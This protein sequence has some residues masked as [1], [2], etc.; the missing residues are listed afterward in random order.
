MLL[1]DKYADKIHGIITCY[2]RMIIQG[3]IPN[4]SHAEAMT[5]YMKLNGIRIF[6]YPTSFSQ[7]LT[8]QVRQNA[9][10]IAHEN[11]MEIEFIR[12]LHAFRKDDR[13][14]NIIA[15]TG[16]TEGLIHIFSAMECCNT[17]RPWHDKTTGK[18]FLKF[19]QSKCLHYYFYFIDRELGLCYLRVPTW[20]P[21]RLQFYMNGHNLLAYKLDKK[22]LSYRMQDN[23]F[24]EIS[25]IETAQKLSDRINPQGLH[26]VLDVFARRYSPVPESLGLGYTWTVQQI[27]CATDIMFRKPEYLAPIYDEIIHTAIYTVKPDNIATFL[28]QRITYNCTK[29]IGTNYNQRILGTRIKHHMGDVSIKMY[30]KFGCVLRIEST[31][32]DISTFRVERE[33]QHRDGTSDIRKAPLKKSIYSLYQLFTILKSANYRYLEFISSFDDHSSGRKKLDEVSHSRREKERTYR[34]FNFFDS[35]DLSVLEA[36]SK[37]NFQ[38]RAQR[39][40]F[41]VRFNQLIEIAAKFAQA[42][43]FHAFSQII[44]IRLLV[45]LSLLLGVIIPAAWNWT[46]AIRNTISP[47]YRSSQ[48]RTEIFGNLDQFFRARDGNE[49][50][51]Q[52]EGHHRG[53]KIGV[54]DFPRTMRPT[55]VTF[56]LASLY[57][58]NGMGL[59]FHASSVVCCAVGFLTAR[60]C[61]SSSINDGRLLEYRV[62]RPNSTA[63]GGA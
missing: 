62:L 42:A 57:N 25:D 24:L 32:N 33:V 9:E 5:A 61:S 1:T 28:G 58:D 18:T 6:D 45:H 26:K 41:G 50:H 34:G 12:K 51:H 47:G 37:I 60:T 7:P 52:K 54:G 55:T 21:F 44:D 10:K 15:E 59:I 35:R 48:R 16:K 31:C 20:P 3:Y 38:M 23:A 19:E 40:Q 30:D 27:E 53:H 13:I 2:D 63:I 46:L 36:I 43:L 22:Q 4:W 17:Y 14:Q 56:M 11:G 29:E 49:P 8:E 39:T